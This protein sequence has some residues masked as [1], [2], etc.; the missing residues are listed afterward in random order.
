MKKKLILLML[1]C[2]LAFSA[3]GEDKESSADE[4]QPRVT[5][6]YDI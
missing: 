5:T 2:V 3:C 6:Q 1:I 4:T